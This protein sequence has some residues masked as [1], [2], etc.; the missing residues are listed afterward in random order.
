MHALPTLAGP[1]LTA[2]PWIGGPISAMPAKNQ[3]P[4]ARKALVRDELLSRAAEVFARQ[5]FAQTR[6]QDIAAAMSLSRS[7]LYHYFTSKEE[8]LAALVE[9]HTERRASEL[10]AI[11][12]DQT[13]P[14]A[15]R[16]RTGLRATIM[17]RLTG[18]VRLLV[19]DQLAIEMPDE[20]RRSFDAGRRHIL[21]LYTG[22]I[23]DGVRQGEFRPVD[24]RIA[25]L[26]VIGIASW[27]SWW[28]APGGRKT[29]DELAD[30]LVDV[31]V[32][33]L[34]AAP[35]EVASDRAGLL[36][37]IRLRLDRLEGG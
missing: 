20:L 32:H 24:P 25:A 3:A 18:G 21:D 36:R 15:E 22:I 14:A 31:A 33:G 1:G 13:H 10:A 30:I 35:A 28:Y 27:T 29:P 23:A 5:G 34:L 17:Q 19:L 11:A 12:A 9:E 2:P 26:A 7:A 8:I 16:L 37:E 4:N 6:I